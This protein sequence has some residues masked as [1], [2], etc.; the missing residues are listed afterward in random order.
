MR[1]ENDQGVALIAVGQVMTQLLDGREVLI[2][3]FTSA[4]FVRHDLRRLMRLIG[5]PAKDHGS[6]TAR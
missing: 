6:N 4:R 2:A 1:T 3:P 5:R